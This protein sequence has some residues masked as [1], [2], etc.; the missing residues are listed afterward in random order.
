[1]RTGILANQ[2]IY[3]A[4]NNII[5]KN[6]LWMVS[7]EKFFIRGIFQNF[8]ES[9]SGSSASQ[10]DSDSLD[11]NDSSSVTDT[12]DTDEKNTLKN[13]YKRINSISFSAKM[14]KD[15]KLLVQ[16]NFI[17][18]ESAKYFKNFL[19]GVITFSRLNSALKENSPG[20][21]IF[22]KLELDNY[23][24]DVFIELKVDD[25]NIKELRETNL[26]KQPELE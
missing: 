17:N 4:I 5:Y 8:I 24:S 18:N 2:K 20:N 13:I 15:L 22:K 14:E 6:D 10:T 23:D 21:N 3:E 11:L 7:T 1:L 19:N 12:A 16:T 26:M 9:T 25:S